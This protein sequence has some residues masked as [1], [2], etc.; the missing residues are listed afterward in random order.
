MT[1]PNDS[2]LAMFDPFAA[3]LNA[4]PARPESD[5]PT[6]EKLSM[7]TFFNRIG[8]RS[9]EDVPQSP[10][11]GNKLIDLSLYNA[12]EFTNPEN[13]TEQLARS[14]SKQAH[15]ELEVKSSR[16]SSLDVSALTWKMEDRLQEMSFDILRDEVTLATDVTE[17]GPTVSHDLAGKTQIDTGANNASKS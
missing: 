10:P 14:P 2:L 8:A 16:R 12:D 6:T 15:I 13:P 9:Q 4:T 3:G 5:G 7:S 17:N 1:D 11:N